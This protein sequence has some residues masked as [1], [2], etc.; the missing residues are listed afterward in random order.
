MFKNYFKVAWR[1]IVRHKGFAFINIFGL[2]IGITCCLMILFWVQD[3][4]SYDKFHQNGNRIFRVVSDWTKYNWKGFEGTPPPLGPSVKTQFPEIKNMTR[5]YS[6]DRKVFRYKA[7]SFYEDRGIIIDPSFFEIFS[8]PFLKGNLR[9]AVSGPGN[10]VITETMAAKYFGGEESMG[11]TILVEGQPQLVCGVLKAIPRHSTLQFDY[12]LSSESNKTNLNWGAFTATT[13]LLLED[14]ADTT[15]I[16]SKITDVGLK[17]ESP[18]VKDGVNFRLQP[19]NDIHLDARAYQ[20]A[21]M[22]LGD[23]SYV[24]L[25]SIIAIFVLLVACI[26]FMNLS[27]ARSGLRAREVGLRKVVG[28]DQ[29]EIIRQF[30]SESFLLVSAAAL[31]ALILFFLLLPTFNQ[32]SGKSLSI[33]LLQPKILISLSAVILATGF[34]SGAYPALILSAFRPVKV[35]KGDIQSEGKNDVFRKIL[36]I[37][38]FSLSIILLIS[39]VVAIKQFRYM[40]NTKLGYATDNIVLLPVKENVGKSYEALKWRLLQ[41]PAIL[42]VTGQEYPFA[43][44]G[45]RSSGNWDWES[46][47]PGKG[48]D[49][50][51]R[52]VDYGFFELMDIPLVAGRSFS[53]NYANDSKRSVILN[54]QAIRDM[55]IKDPIGKWFSV[56]KDDRRIIIGVAKNIHFQTFHFKIEPEVFYIID[57]SKEMNIGFVMV[58]IDGNKTLEALAHM[59]HTWE[60]FNTFSPFEF[61]FLDETYNKLYRSEYQMSYVFS[62]FAGLT[63]LIACLGLLGLTMFTTG[64]RR[65]EIGVRKVLG[66]STQG[67]IHMISRQL[68]KWVLVANILALPVAYFAMSKLLQTYAYRISLNWAIF[69]VPSLTAFLMAYFTVVLHSFWTARMNPVDALRHE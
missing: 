45:Y 52:G 44:T 41:N 11:K 59:R 19:L 18:Q 39:A 47:S 6:D 60:E 57:P 55:E 34:L 63:I 22:N 12:A 64:C 67:I 30:Y 40:R 53:K 29:W 3:E 42:A 35:L 20:K 46:R 13:F 21:I 68:T 32:L 31:I 2:A 24:F 43:E 54:E 50:I 58:K 1:N 56:S 36:V 9:T 48:I 65:K 69:I 66:A 25:F 10:I 62:I 51:Y 7:K 23:S 33:N 38:Q 16:G 37:F 8:F 15:S 27:M 61:R 17:N 5:L 26:N 4:Q 28:A 49:M 14:G